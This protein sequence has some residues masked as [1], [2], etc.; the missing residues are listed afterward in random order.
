MITDKKAL[1]TSVLFTTTV[2]VKDFEM[3]PDGGELQP[4]APTLLLPGTISCW[5][6]VLVPHLHGGI[7]FL[8]ML[9]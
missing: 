4:P 3:Q 7:K 8:Q 2:T 1:F 6:F 9:R 5:C